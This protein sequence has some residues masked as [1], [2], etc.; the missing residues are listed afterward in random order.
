MERAKLLLDQGDLEESFKFITNFIDTQTK[1]NHSDDTKSNIPDESLADAFNTRGHIRY[2]WVDFEEA[3]T[4]YT[5][6]I[7]SNPNLAVAYYN[8]GQVHYRLGIINF[9]YV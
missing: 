2:L 8:R 4:D 3:V 6:A 7:N 9:N 1:L 5:D